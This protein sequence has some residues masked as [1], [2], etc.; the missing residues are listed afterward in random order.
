[1]TQNQ[2]PSPPLR[3]A[4][5]GAGRIAREA[6]IPAWMANDGAE[7]VWVVDNREEAAK[8]TAEIFGIPNWTTDY[9]HLLSREGIDAVD[10]CLPTIAHA[11]VTLAFL[12]QGCHVLLEKP[13][14][15]TLQEARDM[16]RA[17]LQSGVTLMVAENWPFSS[18]MQRVT[19]ILREGE[20]WEPIML[21]AR[22]ESVNRLPPKEPLPREMGDRHRLGYLFVAGIH[23]L[24]LAR[25]LVGEFDALTAY[26]TPTKAGPY[27]PMDDDLVIAARFS[28][29]AVGSFSFTGRS[30]HLGERKLAFRLI[31]DRGVIEFDVLRGW[32]RSTVDGTQTE[33]ETE[34]PSLGYAEEVAHFLECIATGSEPRTSVEDQLRTLAVVLGAY[35][36]LETGSNVNPAS[37]ISENE[38]NA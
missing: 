29:G 16:R 15:L 3:V 27:Y 30:R 26:A 17:E 38:G 25:E 7:L 12:E 31:A 32:V 2:V 10:I 9:K 35:R 22:H 11:E 1:M 19:E 4:L 5:I 28:S 8:E 14:A 6:H 34:S 20:P 24:N 13:V 21:Q 33:F 18:A 23:S 36:S 37:L